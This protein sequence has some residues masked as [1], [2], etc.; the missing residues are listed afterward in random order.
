MVVWV[1]LVSGGVFLLFL[2]ENIG[3][4]VGACGDVHSLMDEPQT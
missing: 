1:V 2:G 3:C 4:C